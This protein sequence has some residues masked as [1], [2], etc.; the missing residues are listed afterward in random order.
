MGIIKLSCPSF[1]IAIAQL[2]PIVSS[3]TKHCEFIIENGRKVYDECQIA[4]AYNNFYINIGPKLAN[5]IDVRNTNCE[6]DTY[7]KDL[8]VSQTMFIKPSSEQE[9]LNIIN[10]F[11]NK[12]SEDVNGLSMKLLKQII[13][14][15]IKPINFICNLSLNTGVFPEQMKIARVLPLFKSG[16]ESSVSNY[17]PVSI[18]P[19]LSKVLEKLFEKRLREYIKKQ[20]VL[21]NGQYGFRKNRSTNTALVEVI[22]KITNAID[23]NK[24]CVG[25]FI[26]LKKAFDTVDHSLL[27]K[28]L[29]FY[30]VRGISSIFLESYLNNRKQFVNFK[31]VNSSEAV[32]KCGVPQG[33]ILRPLLFTLYLIYK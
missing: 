25:V 32:I 23:A 1:C 14:Y 27:L 30:G 20:D 28:K 2:I 17:R 16:D 21:F 18:L 11:A 10:K 4:N 31:N 9:I 24:F 12:G 8:S 19:Q 22:D 13:V 6:Y 5:D 29:R 7:V 15:I 33:S 3:K 26:D